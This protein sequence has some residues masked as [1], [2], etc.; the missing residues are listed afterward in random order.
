MSLTG[1]RYAMCWSGRTIRHWSPC[2]P[3]VWSHTSAGHVTTTHGWL[4]SPRTVPSRTITVGTRTYPLAIAAVVHEGAAAGGVQSEGRRGAGCISGR[5]SGMRGQCRK[6]TRSRSQV[7][8]HASST[9]RAA[10]ASIA[11][12]ASSVS[13]G[14]S[15]HVPSLRS[16]NSTRHAHAARLLPSGSG[17]FHEIP[18]GTRTRQG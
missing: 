6:V 8:S 18:R 17:W 2:S 10:T 15:F 16:M 4:P 12:T 11:A 14:S 13:G 9:S 1:P 3:N 7:A 5:N